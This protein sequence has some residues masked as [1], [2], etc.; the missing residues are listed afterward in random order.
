MV[1]EVTSD[2]CA[3]VR[4]RGGS[5][6]I[7]VCP[8]SALKSVSSEEARD[9]DLWIIARPKPDREREPES[10]ETPETDLFSV[11]TGLCASCS[12]EKSDDRAVAVLTAVVVHMTLVLLSLSSCFSLTLV[13]VL[14]CSTGDGSGR[15]SPPDRLLAS[16]RIL[17]LLELL[18]GADSAGLSVLSG[19]LRGIATSSYT[20]SKSSP[21]SELSVLSGLS[22]LSG[23][24]W[25]SS[26][27]A[28]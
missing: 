5:G 16:S 22:G 25:L 18:T 21:L 11:C 23:L 1:H 10:P 13:G 9:R 4:A 28:W 8:E 2:D 26:S 12:G 14:T 24:S 3:C 20:N 27:R 17:G 7:H 19:L 6:S 15:D